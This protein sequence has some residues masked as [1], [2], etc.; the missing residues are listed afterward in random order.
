MV[1]F[2]DQFLSDEDLRQMTNT[3]SVAE[4][5]RILRKNGIRFIEGK[6]KKINVTWYAVNH[7][8]SYA[9]NDETPNFGVI[10]G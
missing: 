2:I 9:M 8:E 10:N 1:S 6:G 3:D 4:Q 5:K 7:P